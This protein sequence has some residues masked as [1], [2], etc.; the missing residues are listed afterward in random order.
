MTLKIKNVASFIKTHF[1]RKRD[2]LKKRKQPETFHANK[3]YKLAINVFIPTT[4]FSK[5]EFLVLFSNVFFT[6]TK[7]CTPLLFL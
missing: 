3:S 7:L 5:Y 2:C 4:P 6:K 1:Y